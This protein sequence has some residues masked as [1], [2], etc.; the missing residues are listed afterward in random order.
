MIREV[1]MLLPAH[2]GTSHRYWFLNICGGAGTTFPNL[3]LSTSSLAIS[4]QFQLWHHSCLGSN[5][6]FGLPRSFLNLRQ[7]TVFLPLLLMPFLS[8]NSVSLKTVTLS[9]YQRAGSQGLPRCR[10]S[11][12]LLIP[13]NVLLVWPR[14]SHVVLRILFLQAVTSHFQCPLCSRDCT[15]CFIHSISLPTHNKPSRSMSFHLVDEKREAQRHEVAC[16]DLS[17][18]AKF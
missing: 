2:K 7:N 15:R 5:G 9:F 10:M 6:E 17:V 12:G 14:P 4:I 13:S 16:R 18:L 1:R 8:F 11:N 3:S